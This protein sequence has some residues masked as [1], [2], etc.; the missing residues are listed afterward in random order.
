MEVEEPVEGDGKEC[1]ALSEKV[2]QAGET[3][4]EGGP[5]AV[6]GGV[7]RGG[8][9]S[10]HQQLPTRS[11]VTVARAGVTQFSDSCNSSYLKPGL[12]FFFF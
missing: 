6:S 10:V 7:G 11:Q 8:V 4:A 1:R 2:G 3:G 5:A 9:S 12:F